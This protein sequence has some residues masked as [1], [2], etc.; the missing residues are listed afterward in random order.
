[1]EAQKT[2]TTSMD[3]SF[4]VLLPED[5]IIHLPPAEFKEQIFASVANDTKGKKKLGIE[6]SSSA[7]SAQ[8]EPEATEEKTAS[9][10]KSSGNTFVDALVQEA[11]NP[12][13]Q[14]PSIEELAAKNLT[15]TDNAGI[16]HASTESHL[17]DL[18]HT[19][20]GK[21][22]EEKLATLEPLLEEAWKE[23]ALVTLKIIWNCRSI[24]LGKGERS[25]FYVAL[26]WLKDNHPQTLLAN[27]P[28]VTRG[29]IEKVSK[30]GNEEDE[31]PIVIENQAL[32]VDDYEV[33]HGVS[34]GYWKDLLNLLALSANDKLGMK[35]PETI[36]R[37]R[38]REY[39]ESLERLDIELPLRAK[40]IKISAMSADE[41]RVYLGIPREDRIKE[42]Q[43]ILSM[44]KDVAKKRKRVRE[45]SHHEKLWKKFETDTFHRAL[46]NTIARMFA[47]QLRKDKT[48][49]EGGSKEQLKEISLCAKWAPSLERFHDKQTLIATTIAEILF[50]ADNI[51]K[52]GDT[53]EMYLKRAR[54]QYRA[55]ILSPLRK[56]LQVVER[57]ISAN[58][59][60]DIK[61]AQVPSLAMDL[62]KKLFAKKDHDNFL[63]FLLDVQSGK[64]TISGSVL[65]PG[66]LVHQCL[67]ARNDE[68]TRLTLNAQ[69]E[70][71]VQ[72]IKDNGALSDSIAVCDVSGSMMCGAV[73]GATMY[74][75]AIGL[76][77]VLSTVTK[78]PFGG[79]MIT[80]SERPQIVTIGEDGDEKLTFV[81]QVKEVQSMAAGF[82]T[83]FLAVFT[84]A[85]LPL[86]IKNKVKPEDMVKRVFVFS[87]MQ[88]DE[89]RHHSDPW[90]THYQ[91]IEKEYKAA[92]YD[93]PELIFW[94]LSQRKTG[95]APVTQDM[96]GTALVGGQ[97]QAMLKV[98][99]EGGSFDDEDEVEM[100]D[101]GEDNDEFGV[102]E[103]KKKPITP[104]SLLMKAIKHQAYD[105]LTVVD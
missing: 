42:S 33:V 57:Y 100:E 63:K 18:F 2:K 51:K 103:K 5:P 104:L 41:K 16:T 91:I 89:A 13:S 87:D 11:Q 44:Q 94:N 8:T 22:D 58:N 9:A 54:E 65:M 78:A 55:S 47:D 7:F 61:Y 48:I 35:D 88:F 72:R 50:P 77:L 79:K 85:I 4:P 67:H 83:D 92:G 86:A 40:K 29:V 60:T 76:S 74:E 20:D 75:N 90:A 23:D 38:T 24:H 6:D 80:F 26:G 62:Y 98:F 101:E 1:M 36:L 3:S 32:G 15:L 43:K 66:P 73:N 93:V 25:M 14:N 27:L 34:H 30:K 21:P 37:S 82:N 96:P 31:T 19:L 10:T 39:Q 95:S 64:Q 28:W 97:S 102:I 99:L 71:L 12:G 49:L 59:F 105:M 69:W 81:E 17:V 68:I 45:T 52:E 46:H 53:R 56:T 70:T 84:K